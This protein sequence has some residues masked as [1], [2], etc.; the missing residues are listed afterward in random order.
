MDT[1]KV[2]R[3]R[4]GLSQERL[5]ALVGCGADQ[6]SD[7]ETGRVMMSARRLRDIARALGVSCDDIDLGETISRSGAA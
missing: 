3:V 4:A 1:L 6:I 7:Y 2:H 5:A